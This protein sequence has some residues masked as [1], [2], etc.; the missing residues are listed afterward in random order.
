MLFIKLKRARVSYD[1]F[2]YVYLYPNEESHGRNVAIVT[3]Y[4]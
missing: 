3:N 1:I 2:K 4:V